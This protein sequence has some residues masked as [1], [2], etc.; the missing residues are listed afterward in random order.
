[1]N[2]SLIKSEF[3]AL[4]EQETGRILERMKTFLP[5]ALLATAAISPEIM[6][7]TDATFDALEVQA[8]SVVFGPLGKSVIYVASLGGALMAA[9]KGAWMFAGLGIA[10]A[11]LMFGAQIV[12]GG[13]AFSG[14]V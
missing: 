7:G 4:H 9:M 1:M 14:L 13:A 12:A 10:V 11:G 5:V 8:N 6:A 2:T 3:N